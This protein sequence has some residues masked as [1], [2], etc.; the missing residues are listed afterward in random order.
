MVEQL[1]DYERNIFYTINGTHIWWLNYIM[2]AFSSPWVWF[3]LIIVPFYFYWKRRNEWKPMFVCTA[4]TIVCNGIIT[5]LI[6]KPLFKRYRP[7]NHPD[8]MNH[9]TT[10]NDYFANGAYGFISGHATNSFA[11]AM[12]SALIIKKRWYSLLIFA[13]ATLMA[14]SRIYLGAHFIT[15][16]I[17]GIIFGLLIGWGL[18]YL[19]NKT[20]QNNK[21]FSYSKKV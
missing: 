14:Y 15:D 12:L 7:T 18:Y 6:F 20:L 13:W 11:F 2:A 4:L 17:P 16:V 5:S 3:P 10:L 19:Y 8:F 9:V 1:L 21:N